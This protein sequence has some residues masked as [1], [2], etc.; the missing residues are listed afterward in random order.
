[1]SSRNAKFIAIGIACV[2]LL[3]VIVLVVI[4]LNNKTPELP[5]DP[6]VVP[7]V[8]ETPIAEKIIVNEYKITNASQN[9]D[10]RTS[11]PK[12]MN[13]EDK[14]FQEY[15]NRKMLQTV[16]D[17]QKEIEI[18]IDD[19][20]PATALYKYVVSFEKYANDKYLS[21]VVSN[22]YQTGGMR[23]NSWKDTYNI[24]VAEGAI[25][26]VSLKDMFDA[27]A[28]YEAKILEEINT[29]AGVKN[30]ELVGGNGLANLPDGQK[31]YI[32]DGKLV[33][34]FDPAAIAPYVYG[35]LN[36]EM[37]FEYIDGK[38]KV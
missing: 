36:F 17:Y 28:N 2:L 20:T 31:F 34:Y 38:F 37:P 6:I 9:R 18:M 35:E 26:E 25:K 11:I 27:N 8:D 12:I 1:M 29:Q 3:V 10:I 4:A 24:C 19:E 33:I 32:R 22:D 16:S 14:G 13:L 7:P 5:D 15:I 21:L 23:S 30:Y